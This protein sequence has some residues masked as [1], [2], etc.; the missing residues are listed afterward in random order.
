ME[1]ECLDDSLAGIKEFRIKDEHKYIGNWV[2]VPST[3]GVVSAVAYGKDP[4]GVGREARE[5]GVKDYTI[6]YI[7]K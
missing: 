1:Q 3:N 2:A 6:V 7:G 4:H 5:K